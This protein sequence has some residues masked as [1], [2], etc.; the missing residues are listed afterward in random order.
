M[1]D[2][3]HLAGNKVDKNDKRKLVSG[4]V[5]GNVGEVP[6]TLRNFFQISKKPLVEKSSPNDSSEQPDQEIRFKGHQIDHL[7]DSDAPVSHKEVPLDEDMELELAEPLSGEVIGQDT[8]SEGI[9]GPK[10]GW[11]G[12]DSDMVVG[13]YGGEGSRNMI[14]SASAG[15][16]QNSDTAPARLRNVTL[17]GDP[18]DEKVMVGS[19]SAG[20]YH[21]KDG[22]ELGRLET[23]GT[24]GRV[25]FASANLNPL[26]AP[27]LPNDLVGGSVGSTS[28]GSNLVISTEDAIKRVKRPLLTLLEVRWGGCLT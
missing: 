14:G 3:E 10:L 26:A 25:G 4:K 2:L 13:E 9:A 11:K 24:A 8:T 18:R 23:A 12:D 19:A 1:S 27:S 7:Q 21:D 6:L 15:P 20:L 22:K 17:L 28:V 16:Y 5:I